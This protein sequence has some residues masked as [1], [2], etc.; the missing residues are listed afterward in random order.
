M[1][2]ISCQKFLWWKKSKFFH[3]IFIVVVLILRAIQL[4]KRSV[5][6]LRAVNFL[7]KKS[8]VEKLLSKIYE[9]SG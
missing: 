8:M 2:T 3:N 7:Y 1:I 6:Y 4:C 5:T 9:K